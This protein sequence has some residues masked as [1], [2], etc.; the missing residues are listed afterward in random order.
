MPLQF[1]FSSVF[2][3]FKEQ[4]WGLEWSSCVPGMLRME[5]TS[6]NGIARKGTPIHMMGWPMTLRGNGLEGKASFG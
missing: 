2:F 1:F 6:G 4:E 5:E 3:F